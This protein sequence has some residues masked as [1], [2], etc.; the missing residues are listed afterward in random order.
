MPPFELPDG[1]LTVREQRY[2]AL[3]IVYFAAQRRAGSRRILRLVAAVSLLAWWV[4]RRPFRVA[5]YGESM[6]PT[7]DPGDFLIATRSRRVVRGSLVLVDHPRR[8]GY[9]MVKRVAALPGEEAG[10]G[11]LGPTEFWLLGDNGDRSTDSRQFGPVDRSAVRG[12]IAWRYW[13][14]SRAGRV[15]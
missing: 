14:L 15:G 1:R 4:A 9:E 2:H 11:K 5:V 6:R 7:L 12:V 13:P 10:P 3:R 8:P